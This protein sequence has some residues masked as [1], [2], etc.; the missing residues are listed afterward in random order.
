MSNQWRWWLPGMLA[1]VTFGLMSLAAA[2]PDQELPPPRAAKKELKEPVQIPGPPASILDPATMPI[3]L[4]ASL[5]LA[6]V[7]NPEI[8][9]A[10]Q[11]VLEAVALSQLA[12]AQLL[13]NLNAG[14][15]F[16]NHTGN[17]QQ[18]NG[19]IL[20]VN[21][22]SMYAGLGSLAVAAGTVNI[23]G[24]LMQGNISENVFG[25]L[26]ANQRVKQLEWDSQAVR[27]DMLLRV[28]TAYVDLLHAE[29]HRAIALRTRGEGAEVARVTADYAATG[30]GRPADA[31]RAA[32]DLAERDQ[33]ILN[34]E[35]EILVAAARLAQA[36]NLDPS[37]RLFA[38]DGWVVPKPLVPEPI[39]LQELIAIAMV[40]R[41]ELAAQQAAIRG[42]FLVLHGAKVLPFSPNYLLGYSNGTFGGGSNI[43]SEGAVSANGVPINQPRFGTFDDR[44]DVDV[45]LYW[46]LRNLGIGN[47]ALINQASARLEMSKLQEVVVLNR[48]RAEVATAYA[49]THARFA[50]IGIMEQAV[51]TSTNGFAADLK[52]TKGL[53][54]L[55]IE[56]LDS[57]RLLGQSRLNY[58][59]AITD[60]NRAQF[61]LYVALGQPPADVLARPIPPDL[62][63]PASVK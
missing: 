52:R 16:D 29:G 30:Q 35:N 31:D 26:V 10:Q 54:G 23:P 58:L 20:N 21:R 61:E 41:P 17:L 44:Q 11:R 49:R 56:V 51:K 45:V 48:V 22:G 47:L 32:A 15:S 12:A 5:K 57:L 1:V 3:T 24:V 37:V 8:Q 63:P 60:Y 18:A 34:A 36:L 19:T 55:P 39:P 27:N 38:T 59:Q 40:Q 9:L 53:Q 6:G 25:I 33:D 2:P 62:V 13:P 14:T 43:V 4:P 42:A 7:E 46:T 28:A 50:Q